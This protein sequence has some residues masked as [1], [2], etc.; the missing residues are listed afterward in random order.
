MMNPDD[1]DIDNVSVFHSRGSIE[2]CFADCMDGVPH[3]VHHRADQLNWIPD[4]SR[5]WLDYFFRYVYLRLKVGGFLLIH[6]NGTKNTDEWYNSTVRDI[7]WRTGFELAETEPPRLH[8][9]EKR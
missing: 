8:K 1:F 6:A 7:A 5:S 2:Q 3:D 4:I 9:W